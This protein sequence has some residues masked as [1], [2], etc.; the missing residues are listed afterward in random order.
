[1]TNHGIDITAPIEKLLVRVWETLERAG[2]GLLSPWQIRRMEKAVADVRRHE[3][4]LDAQTAQDIEAI[5]SGR[6][7]VGPD[8]NLLRLPAPGDRIEP[9]PPTLRY[10]P[11]HLSAVLDERDRVAGLEK[12][13]NARDVA[14]RADIEAQEHPPAG[15]SENVAAP[16]LEWSRHW[17]YGAEG[18]SESEV[19]QLWAQVLVKEVA[20]PNSFSV[21]T[22]RALQVFTKA[23]ADLF[24][25]MGPFILGNS[26]LL[27]DS[28]LLER[29]GITF[30]DLVDLQGLGLLLNPD[31]RNVKHLFVVTE[32]PRP[33]LARVTPTRCIISVGTNRAIVVDS[34]TGALLHLEVISLTNVAR[35][36]L[37]LGEFF[38]PE[39]YVEEV[40]QRIG[41][42]GFEV[43]IGDW[44]RTA[45]GGEVRNAIRAVH[46]K[47]SN[48][49]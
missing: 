7:T 43:S 8:G 29:H 13:L 34:H 20:R 25:K 42:E 21:R 28:R 44:V 49:D 15:V 38:A 11:R 4:L 30:L 33:P 27:N 32:L 10:E 41:A 12:L 36:L 19:R 37:K 16:S 23:D 26:F 40:A 22:L 18:A 17:Q 35:E 14:R 9:L 31:S 1:M 46:K 5:K 45:E 3:R 47:L 39:S 48:I 2:T 24:A 6:A